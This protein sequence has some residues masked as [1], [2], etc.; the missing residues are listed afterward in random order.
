LGGG[1]EGVKS[2]I[3]GARGGCQGGNEKPRGRKGTEKNELAMRG[4]GKHRQFRKRQLKRR[5]EGSIG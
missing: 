5:G 2:T 3:K 1:K 4:E